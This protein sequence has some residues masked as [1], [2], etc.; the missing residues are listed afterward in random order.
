MKD[1]CGTT[2][3]PKFNICHRK[4]YEIWRIVLRKLNLLIKSAT[5]KSA[6]NSAV[7]RTKWRQHLES[8]A[9]FDVLPIS[10]ECDSQAG[11]SV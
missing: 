2:L 7:L 10:P 5:S 1:I 4:N 11:L 3:Q 6:C 8:N 9:I